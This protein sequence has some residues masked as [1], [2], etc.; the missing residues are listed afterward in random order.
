M[1]TITGLTAARMQAIEDASVV[2]GE[3]I[4]DHL[5]LTKFDGNTIDTG[6]VVGPEGPTG[7]QGPQGSLAPL[8]INLKTT[9]YTL[10]ITDAEAVIEMSSASATTVTIPPESSEDFPVG[11]TVTIARLGSGDVTIVAGSGVTLR[12]SPGL[13]LAATNAVASLY[14]RGSDD[15]VVAGN[16]VA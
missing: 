15:W 7:P 1:T 6:V 5:I 16:L 4:G 14:K 9:S 13:K 3:I 10:A 8:D 11:T 12:A 2:D